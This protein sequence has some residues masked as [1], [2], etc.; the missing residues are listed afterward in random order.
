MALWFD[1]LTVLQSYLQLVSLSPCPLIPWSPGPLA[2]H[3]GWSSL[4]R[5]GRARDDT[6]LSPKH[7]NNIPSPDKAV[8][9]FSWGVPADYLKT[10]QFQTGGGL[11]HGFQ[12]V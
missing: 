5:L 1:C 11:F 2:L 7:L 4:A 12:I 9:H 3:P 10:V 6:G 8:E